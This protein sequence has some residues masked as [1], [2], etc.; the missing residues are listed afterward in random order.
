MEQL[1]AI[2]NCLFKVARM[3]SQKCE[4]LNPRRPLQSRRSLR[5]MA[6]GGVPRCTPPVSEPKP[7]EMGEDDASAGCHRWSISKKVKNMLES[8]YRADQFPSTETRRRLAA[9]LGALTD[10]SSS[11]DRNI[12]C[13]L[14]HHSAPRWREHAGASAAE[15]RTLCS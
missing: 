12:N 7:T 11:W 4:I 14:G 13:E 2:I 8:V 6:T 3:K 9:E 15:L 5:T 1:T 10:E